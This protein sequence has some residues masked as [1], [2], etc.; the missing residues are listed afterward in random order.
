MTT[1][2]PHGWLKM[3]FRFLE[4]SREKGFHNA[5]GGDRRSRREGLSGEDI[6]VIFDFLSLPLWQFE[7]DLK[8]ILSCSFVTI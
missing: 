6:E 3:F 1:E 4:K 5:L 2:Y 7:N 8:T